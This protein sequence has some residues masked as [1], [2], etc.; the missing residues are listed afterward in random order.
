MVNN[1]AS[2]L[3]LA[4]SALSLA[5]S[6]DAFWRLPCRGRSGVG[7]LDPIMDPGKVSDHVHVIHGGSSMFLIMLSWLTN[8]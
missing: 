6:A 2:A 8:Y 5:G 4:V 7:R 3:S 1:K